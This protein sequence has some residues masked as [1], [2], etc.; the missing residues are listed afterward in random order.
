[1]QKNEEGKQEDRK[2]DHMNQY[3]SLTGLRRNNQTLCVRM[4]FGKAR[5]KDS[6]QPGRMSAEYQHRKQSSTSKQTMFFDN[7]HLKTHS[8][9]CST[10]FPLNDYINGGIDQRSIM[11]ANGQLA[12]RNGLPLEPDSNWTTSQISRK[13]RIISSHSIV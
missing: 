3:C 7:V 6:N 12:L 10:C 1:M 5:W 13:K 8:H 9:S 2:N 11:S 4:W